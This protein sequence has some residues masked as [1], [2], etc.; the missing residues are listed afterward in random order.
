MKSRF[1]YHYETIVKDELMLKFQYS[2]VH[3]V[4]RIEKI[5]VDTSMKSANFKLKLAPSL[6]L[7]LTLISGQKAT[8]TLAR[9]GNAKLGIRK[10]AVTGAKVTLRNE[11][12]FQ[13]VDFLITLVLPRVK[14]FE[15]LQAKS[16]NAQGNLTIQIKD[17]FTFPQ[18]EAATNLFNYVGAINITIVTSTSNK[19]ESKCLLR[20][21]SIP[22]K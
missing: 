4:P 16:L 18:L 14:N 19:E 21:L 20:G 1:Y 17:P 8:P 22:I 13:F 7:A 11:K 5:V 15:G 2:N 12:M 6:I 9:K 3:E 10:G